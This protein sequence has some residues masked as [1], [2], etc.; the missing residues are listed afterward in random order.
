MSNIPKMGQL[1]TPAWLVDSWSFFGAEYLPISIS[2]YDEKNL[3]G[4]ECT[5][6]GRVSNRQNQQQ[7]KVVGSGLGIFKFVWKPS[8]PVGDFPPTDILFLHI[9]WKYKPLQAIADHSLWPCPL[10]LVSEAIPGVLLDNAW[11][12]IPKL[13]MVCHGH[14]MIVV[15]QCQSYSIASIS[16][17]KM[18]E[19]S[20]ENH[21]NHKPS[22]TQHGFPPFI[23]R[24]SNFFLSSSPWLHLG[25]AHCRCWRQLGNGLW[26]R[27]EYEPPKK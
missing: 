2:S 20:W 10:Q 23:P 14:D 21:G 4:Y 13:A 18:F 7:T 19:T 12:E 9:A 15:N 25:R 16:N 24:L 3:Y 1:P 17:F 5:V 11:A 22:R 6:L 26:R 8:Q 27:K